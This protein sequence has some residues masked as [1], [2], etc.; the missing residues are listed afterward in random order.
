MEEHLAKHEGKEQL[1]KRKKAARDSRRDAPRIVVEK[2]QRD[3]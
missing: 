3:C 1:W 2:R